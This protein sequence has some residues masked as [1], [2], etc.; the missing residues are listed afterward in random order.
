MSRPRLASLVLT[1]VVLTACGKKDAPPADTKAPVV[2]T[3]APPPTTSTPAPKTA[4][5]G[6][7]TQP[8]NGTKSAGPAGAKG[9]ALTKG[10]A[11]PGG[12]R[13]NPPRNAATAPAPSSGGPVSG[14]LASAKN[15]R[16]V[17]VSSYL[18]SPPANWWVGE[19]KRQ[20]V[21]AYLTQAQVNGQVWYRIRVGATTSGAEAREIA[22]KIHAKYKWPTWIV[23]VEDKSDLSPDALDATRTYLASSK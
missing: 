4:A 6:T 13:T 5:P 19:L 11:A 3:K 15:V 20:G 12:A 2:Q 18:T 17:Q 10:A 22:A 21:P 9:A 14:E 16:T 23:M 7:K 1:L 8:M